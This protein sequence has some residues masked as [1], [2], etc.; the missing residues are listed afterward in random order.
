VGRYP[1]DPVFHARLGATDARLGR[2]LEAIREGEKAV[3]LRPLSQDAV[4]G[5][6]YRLH[7]AWILAR[8]GQADAAI[9]QLTYLLSVPS[10]VSVPALRVDHIWDPLRGNPRFQRLVQGQKR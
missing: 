4:G 2:N 3:S 10:Y 9:D 5:T 8:V 7:L 1:D 6:A